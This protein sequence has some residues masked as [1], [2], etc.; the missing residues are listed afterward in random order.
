MKSTLF[1][2]H[3]QEVNETYLSHLLNAT[4]IS[5]KLGIACPMQLLHGLFPFI[6]PPM[7]SNVNS[8][9]E[10]LNS[11]HPQERKRCNEK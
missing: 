9:I 2:K 8:L 5:I 10:Y 1:T 11:M 7:N 3:L 6:C 4:K